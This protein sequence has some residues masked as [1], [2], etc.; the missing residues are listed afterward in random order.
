MKLA[1]STNAFTSFT[2]ADAIRAI[3]RAG[4][5]GVEIMADT[6]HAYPPEMTPEKIARARLALA[7]T[8]LQISNVNAFMLK[9]IGDFWRPSWI[10][11]Q[12][13]EREKRIQHTIN[14][15]KLAQALGAPSI[16]T[17]PGG[18]LDGLD[19]ETARKWFD[20]GIMRCLETAERCG[21]KL[22]IEPEPGL[23]IETPDHVEQ[24]FTRFRSP[25]LGLNFDVG[26]FYCVGADIPRA[27]RRFGPDIGH[28]HIED[29]AP[30]RRHHHLIPGRGAINFGEIFEALRS[31]DYDGWLTVELYTEEANPLEAAVEALKRLKPFLGH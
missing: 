11:R 13:A 6:P 1:F 31:A 23:L 20:E 15:L 27:I 4:Y 14:S 7:E 24:F 30:D 28:V 10:E 17:E 21:V 12:K 29:I 5:S 8:G 16:S 2:L 22:L 9:A 19:A 18:P 26:H 3:A 25:W